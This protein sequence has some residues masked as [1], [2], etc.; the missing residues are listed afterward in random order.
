MPPVAMSV[1]FMYVYDLF[2][3]FAFYYE[4][5]GYIMLA[6]VVG[7][8]LN[9]LLNWIFIDKYGYTAAGYTTLVCYVVYAITHYIMM[10][11]VCRKNIGKIQVYDLRILLGI[12]GGFVAVGFIGLGLYRFTV[13]RYC[14]I[15]ILFVSVVLKR[16]AIAKAVKGI[17]ESKKNINM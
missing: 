14:F 3:K 7:A 10:R 6:S 16:K 9:I 4:K 1:F 2:A 17:L 15:G 12:T 8:A 13:L 11:I 5:T